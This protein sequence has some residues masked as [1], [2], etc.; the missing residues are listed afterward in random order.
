M[1]KNYVGEPF[2][3]SLISGI[4]TFYMLKR[5]TSRFSVDCFLSYST[6]K[7]RRANLCLTNFLV[8]KKFKDKRGGGRREGVS[9]FSIKRI[10]SLSA[11]TFVGESF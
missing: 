10:L 5:F 4:E 7:L 6:E 11:K 9:P 8:S 3:F 2:N 1:P